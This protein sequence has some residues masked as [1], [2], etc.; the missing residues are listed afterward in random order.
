MVRLENED[1]LKQEFNWWYIVRLISIFQLESGW[2]G[3]AGRVGGGVVVLSK[4][5]IQPL[6][7]P[8]FTVVCTFLRI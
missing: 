5:W 4:L 3:L 6:Q 1:C 7:K 2:G 8:G